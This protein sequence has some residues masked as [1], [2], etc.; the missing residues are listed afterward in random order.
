MK[1]PISA[2]EIVELLRQKHQHPW[3]FFHELRLGTGYAKKAQKRVDAFAIHS[4]PSSK[5][6]KIAYE[7]KI[8]KSDFLSEIKNPKKRIAA[9]ELSNQFYFCGPSTAITASL[10]PPECGLIE[11]TENHSLKVIK[12]AP[13]RDCKP[14]EWLFFAAISRRIAK[15]EGIDYT[16]FSDEILNAIFDSL[17]QIKGLKAS[18]MLLYSYIE[19]E[20]LRRAKIIYNKKTSENR[21]KYKFYSKIKKSNPT[22]QLEELQKLWQ[23]KLIKK[24]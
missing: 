18:E 5:F 4:Y 23:E 20:K 13:Y 19:K 2:K 1:S 24:I 17:S 16:Q 9:L 21:A 12:E 7:I 14:P 10:V 11:V 22:I 8:S 3:C 6:L 15:Q